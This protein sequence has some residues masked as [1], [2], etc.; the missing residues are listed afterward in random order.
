MAYAA[1]I[2][3]RHHKNTPTGFAVVDILHHVPAQDGRERLLLAACIAHAAPLDRAFVD[4]VERGKGFAG[5]G[6]LRGIAAEAHLHALVS[7]REK[8]ADAGIA[9]ATPGAVVLFALA[10]RM[11]A[12]LVGI[13]RSVSIGHGVLRQRQRRAD[14]QRT[15]NNTHGNNEANHQATFTAAKHMNL[16]R[17]LTR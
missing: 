6:F 16:W 15:R 8:H 17:E 9:R 7:G 3:P 2:E 10:A 5:R 4:I 1:G 11:L 14:Q 12:A 13:K